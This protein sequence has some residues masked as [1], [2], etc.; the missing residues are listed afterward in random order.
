MKYK[1]KVNYDTGDSFN[2]HTGVED[3]VEWDHENLDVAKENIRRMM[4]HHDMHERLNGWGKREK[5]ED[6]LKSCE[7][8]PWFTPKEG[9]TD[10][11][12]QLKVKMD[13]GNDVQIT[14]FWCG[15]FE[16]LNFFQIVPDESDLII[17][18]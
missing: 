15:Y 2:T 10:P 12:Y 9:Y 17:Y 5:R 1:I 14:A 13:N 4:A 18:A 7:N 6:V 16:H 8:E 11:E 3:F